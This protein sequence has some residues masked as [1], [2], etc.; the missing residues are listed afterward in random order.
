MRATLREAR[1]LFFRRIP[2]APSFDIPPSPA[3]LKELKH[4]WVDPRASAHWDIDARTLASMHN[5]G[6]HGL[7]HMPPI[8]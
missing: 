8:D 3:F 2:A 1:D 6:E 7:V 5:A 4:C